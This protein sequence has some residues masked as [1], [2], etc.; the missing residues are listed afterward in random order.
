MDRANNIEAI[1]FDVLGTMVDEPGSLRTAIRN[2]LPAADDTTIDQLLTVW[3]HHVANEQ[4]R[5]HEGTR[6]YANSD[7]IDRE[8]AHHVAARSGL[9][10][11]DTIEQLATASQRMKPWNDSPTALASLAAHFPVLALTHASRACLLRLNAHAGLRWH[12]ALSAEDA[13]AY[14][15]APQVYQLALNA[16]QCPPQ[17]VLMVAAHAWD[18]RGAQ[19][20]GILTA[21][22]HRPTGNPRAKPTPLTGTRTTSPNSPTPWP[23]HRS[24]STHQS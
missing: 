24:T 18:L 6:P 19:S 1:V 16:A 13:Q 7:I 10:D 20:H 14:K 2:A 15:P 23:H 5:I 12:Q 3:Q 11:P 8:A 9:T 21:Y 22:I 17:H 4:Q